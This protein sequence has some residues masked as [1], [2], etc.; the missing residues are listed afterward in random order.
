MCRRMANRSYRDEQWGNR[1]SPHIKPVN[2]L[3]DL[4][5]RDDL[6]RWVPYVAPSYGGV[7]AELL[8]VLQDPGPK[9]LQGT[10]S[11]FISQENDDPTAER[12][13]DFMESANISPSR[14]MLWNAYPWYINQKPK[15][16]DLK[17][18]I[19]PLLKLLDLLPCLKVVMLNG[20][21]AQ[22]LWRMVEREHATL[23][24]QFRF[25][26]ISTFHTS[27][28]AMVKTTNRDHV[29]AAFAHAGRI[30]GEDNT[31]AG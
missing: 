20:L 13:C 11:G 5:I 25:V 1:Y 23:T 6:N 9:T 12:L 18:G 31:A 30:L 16:S 17:D 3:V 22:N 8:N 27:N 28:R 2:E 14:A 7:N 19:K 24:Q 29:Q 10:G 4:I 15:A 26:V 21:V